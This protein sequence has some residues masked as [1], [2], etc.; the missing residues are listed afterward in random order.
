MSHRSRRGSRAGAALAALALVLAGCG[1]ASTAAPSA[2]STTAGTAASAFPHHPDARVLTLE[3]P[4]PYRPVSTD[5]SSDDYHCTLVDPHL[6]TAAYI[7]GTE[8]LPGSPEVHHAIMYEVLPADVPR[9][10]AADDHSG[11][12]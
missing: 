2:T 5:G 6:R 12:T 7:T 9:A 8:F 4:H 11:A 10:V 3:A 1:G